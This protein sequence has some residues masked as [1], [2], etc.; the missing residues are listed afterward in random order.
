MNECAVRSDLFWNKHVLT[1]FS[2][3]LKSFPKAGIYRVCRFVAVC[4]SNVWHTCCTGSITL[5]AFCIDFGV[6]LAPKKRLLGG[7]W[8]LHEKVTWNILSLVSL[9]DMKPP[10]VFYRWRFHMQKISKPTRCT[11]HHRRRLSEH[12]SEET[13][14]QQPQH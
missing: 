2:A 9:E 3:V 11:P 4:C 12:L 7:G 8:M 6:I 1:T 10:P 14:H 13:S 5:P